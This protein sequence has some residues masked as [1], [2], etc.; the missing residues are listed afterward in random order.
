MLGF[1]AVI[2]HI[3]QK[4]FNFH[5]I[6]LVEPNETYHV[7]HGFKLQLLQLVFTTVSVL[8]SIFAAG[9]VYKTLDEFVNR[10]D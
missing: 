7:F 2:S 1:G 9:I 6:V 3:A 8:N 10:L 5:S 4:S